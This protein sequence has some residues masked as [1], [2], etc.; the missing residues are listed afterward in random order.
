MK[1]KT[2]QSGFTLV[3][4]GIVV[5]IAAVI[6]GIGL[7]VVP[8]VLAATRANGEISDL[9]AISTKIQRA[10]ANQPNFSTPTTASMAVLVN[11]RV[12]P[13][14]MVS[15]TTVTNRWG[16]SLTA[17][18]STLQTAND[19][20]TL[21]DTNVPGPECNQVV[22]GI[23]RSYRQ[24]KVNATTVKADGDAQVNLA[25]LGTACNAA[26]NNAIAVTFGK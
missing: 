3:E 25:T 22:Q 20:V 15:G 26:G 9:P 17:A 7:V 13:E 8:S 6:I 4:L 14:N 10:F 19:S 11:L 1:L 16:G 21:T 18:V 24:I 5:A 12:F 23:D 2:K